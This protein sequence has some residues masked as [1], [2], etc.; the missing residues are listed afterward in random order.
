MAQQVAP[1]DPAWASVGFAGKKVENNA[2][3]VII[4][5]FENEAPIA[6][7]LKHMFTTTL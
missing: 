3:P 5:L 7:Q 6:I 1:P 4:Y 2:T